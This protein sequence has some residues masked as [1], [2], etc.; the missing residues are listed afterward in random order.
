ML[1]LPVD[2]FR[3]QHSVR[4]VLRADRVSHLEGVTP[5]IWKATPCEKVMKAAEGGHDLAFQ[6]ITFVAPD[7]AARL[8]ETLCNIAEVSQML[9]PLLAIRAPHFEETLD[10]IQSAYTADRMGGYVVPAST[11]LVPSAVSE[12]DPLFPA[13]WQHLLRRFP[14]AYAPVPTT[15][16]PIGPD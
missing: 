10:W 16:C 9:L 11:V 1:E 7:G 2:A 8:L 3:V 5:S 14:G 6:G 13:I 15:I 12:G 4:A